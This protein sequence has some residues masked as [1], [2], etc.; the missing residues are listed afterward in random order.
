METRSIGKSSSPHAN[1]P[2]DSQCTQSSAGYAQT[3]SAANPCNPPHAQ[4]FAADTQTER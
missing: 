1:S 3:Q 2:D 4:I